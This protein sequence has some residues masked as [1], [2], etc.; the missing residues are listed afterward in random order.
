MQLHAGAP[1]GTVRT[2]DHVRTFLSS[3]APSEQA[4]ADLTTCE[5]NLP[6][7]CSL[8]PSKLVSVLALTDVRP[9]IIYM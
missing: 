8:A 4:G 2:A 1:G 5:A 7:H 3:A 6:F 9:L